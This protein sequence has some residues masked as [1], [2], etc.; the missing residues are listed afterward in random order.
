MTDSSNH[1][2]LESED[3]AT[4]TL[5]RLAAEAKS[6]LPNIQPPKTPGP[7]DITALF[8]RHSSALRPGQLVKD[9]F[10]TLFEAVGALEI[11]DPKMDSGFVHEGDSFDADFDVERNLEPGEVLWVM[12]Q[13]LC[14]EIEWLEGYPL[15]QTVFT[16]LHVARLLEPSNR[17]AQ[18]REDGDRQS[19]GENL[20]EMLTR[21]VLRA[22]CVAMIKCME[23]C[24]QAI[25]GQTYY[26]EEDFVTHLF[27][28]ELLPRIT[29]D[30][31]PQI[32][33]EA[34]EYVQQTKSL[35]KDLS[36]ALEH[37]L[38][39]QWNMLDALR[40]VPFDWEPMLDGIE[41]IKES[42][43]LATPVPEAF[44]SKVQRQ[45]ATSTPPRPML[46]VSWNEAMTKWHH[47]ISSVLSAY[48][49]TSSEVVVDPQCLQRATWAFAYRNPPPSTLPR[50]IFQE[51][52]FHEQGPV[53]TGVGH[54]EL[55]LADLRNT[56]LAGDSLVDPASFQ[57]EL[58]SDPRHMRARLLEGFV[59]KAFD[60]Y[61]NI[62]RMVCQN[63]CRI[64]R[65][66]TQ[67]VAILDALE[68]EGA[69]VDQAIANVSVAG[70]GKDTLQKEL[71]PLSSWAKFNKLRVIS[72]TIQM[73]FETEIYMK[74][75]VSYSVPLLKPL[76]W[77][78]TNVDLFP[79]L[80]NMYWY[81]SQLTA[82]QLQLIQHI[83]HHL[84]DRTNR[85]HTALTECIASQLYL[86]STMMQAD[87]TQALA[88]ALSLFFN[89]L[90]NLNIITS[91]KREY[92]KQQLFHEARMKPYLSIINDRVP[93]TSD[94]ENQRRAN[95]GRP[96]S[97]ICHQIDAEI[98][99]A[100]AFLGELK[101]LGPEEGKF[102]GTEELFKKEMK[103]LET[104]CV[105]VAVN[106]SQLGRLVEKFGEEGLKEKVECAMERRWHE[107]WV[108]PVVK[109]KK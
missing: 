101:K 76:V 46:T 78:D 4:S 83:E 49:L 64:R 92:A 7:Q 107:W 42:H 60:E 66:F 54:Y 88:S 48:S 36:D 19:G 74:D 38:V 102:L 29:G 77:R 89:H 73:G 59:E 27:G 53:A 105:A 10:F 62:Y 8:T 67:A 3:I 30:E 24:M 31:A 12:D 16:S 25:Q 68:S 32:I 45:L 5:D 61:L 47:L 9:D 11:M 39:F 44:S 79:Q 95:E 18:F 70:K 91:P 108:V 57:V 14:L 69:R 75:E 21:R 35:P 33:E 40:D 94:F 23:M 52:L 58:P 109:E 65:L 84:K 104:T 96:T 86:T 15:S 82:S 28:R 98:K 17:K 50:A 55:F 2:G 63:R 34:T 90:Q 37:R 80:G 43:S 85:R 26:E 100:K 81:L 106:A 13:L 6:F 71:R 51:Q 1:G 41:R 97:E 93:S 56:V 99:R 103:A 72:W 22:Y 20:D 87:A